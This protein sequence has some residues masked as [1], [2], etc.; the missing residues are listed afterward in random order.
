MGLEGENKPTIDPKG[1]HTDNPILRGNKRIIDPKGKHTDKPIPRVNIR[2]IVSEG[3]RTDKPI[4]RGNKRT[5]DTN[6]KHTDNPILRGNKRIIDPKGKHTDKPIPRVNIRTIQSQGETSDNRTECKHT[7]N[8]ILRGNKRQLAPRVNIRTSIENYS[9]YLY[10]VSGKKKYYVV[11]EGKNP[12]IYENWNDCQRQISGVAEARFRSF[13]NRDE[14]LSAFKDP[15]SVAPSKKSSKYFYVIWRGHRPGIYTSWED[16]Q[17]QIAGFG[18]ALYKTFGSKKMA[19][20]AFAGNPSD[21]RDGN[22]K[23]TRSYTKEQLEKIGKPIEISLCVDAACNNTGNFEYQG[24]W[25]FSK[26]TV[27]KVGPLKKGSNNIGEFLGLVHALAWLSKH[28]DEKMKTLPIYTDS[29]IAMS[30]VRQ[31]VCKTKKSPGPD[32]LN[33]IARAEKWLK[34]N[35][36]KNPILKWET[37]VWGE[38][39]ADFGRK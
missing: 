8:P 36:W 1:K 15:E 13:E 2:T 32:V 33:L 20:E 25:T 17:K 24:V 16:A 9:I 18:G 3:K 34:S 19:E 31:K 26:D 22:F 7:D 27:F 10:P 29:K 11:W 6:G 39:P 5:I 35:A 28:R 21:Y 37:R 14:A 4:P 38:I 23:K 30:W 12:G